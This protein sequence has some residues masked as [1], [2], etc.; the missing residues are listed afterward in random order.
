MIT[1]FHTPT[2]HIYFPHA[3]KE[4]VVIEIKKVLVRGTK[5]KHSFTLE[6]IN[7][8]MV[9]RD[10]FN[11]RYSDLVRPHLH[12]LYPEDDTVET[13]QTIWAEKQMEIAYSVIRPLFI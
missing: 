4:E 11:D 13:A 3:H 9:L 12:L 1:L 10:G 6:P 5:G 2:I 7:D 8:V